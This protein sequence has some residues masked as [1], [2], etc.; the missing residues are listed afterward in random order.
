V[1][2]VV[3]VVCDVP[4]LDPSSE[5]PARRNNSSYNKQTS[6]TKPKRVLLAELNYAT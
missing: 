6:Q 4:L 2:G 5:P 1:E 3:L